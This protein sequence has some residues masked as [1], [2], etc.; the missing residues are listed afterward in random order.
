[1]DGGGDSGSPPVVVGGAVGLGGG[2]GSRSPPAVVGGGCSS[3]NPPA[4]VLLRLVQTPAFATSENVSS[5]LVLE[6]SNY[7]TRGRSMMCLGAY[8]FSFGE[9]VVSSSSDPPPR[10]LSMG[11]FSAFFVFDP[12]WTKVTDHVKGTMCEGYVT[13][14]L[15]RYVLWLKHHWANIC[16]GCFIPLRRDSDKM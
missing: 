3:G 11:T 6:I 2:N 5:L 12:I 9:P 1:M 8:L 14:Y 16:T 13:T 7:L 15:F 10:S 4:G